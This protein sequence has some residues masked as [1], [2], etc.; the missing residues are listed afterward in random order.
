MFQNIPVVKTDGDDNKFTRTKEQFHQAL[1]DN[2]T[3]RF[4]CDELLK[5]ALVL[6]KINWPTDQIELALYGDREVSLL[7][8]GLGYESLGTCDILTEFT[9]YKKTGVSGKRLT[10]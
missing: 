10:S 8:K 7:C 6:N 2:V 3:Q 9:V 5:C 1:F 4:P